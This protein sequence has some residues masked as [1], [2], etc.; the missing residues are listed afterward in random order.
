MLDRM[1]EQ[2]L[3]HGLQ[4]QQRAGV[5][6]LAGNGTSVEHGR[7]ELSFL[8]RSPADDVVV[9]VGLFDRQEETTGK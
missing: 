2:A 6:D 4:R 1:I 5:V 3:L 9:V 7:K 8:H